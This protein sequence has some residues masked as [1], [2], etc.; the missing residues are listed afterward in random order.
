MSRSGYKTERSL[1]SSPQKKAE[2]I[3]ILDKKFN[4]RRAVHNKSGRK[5][6]ELRG[7]KEEWI[8]NFSERLDI[9]YATP[10]RRDTG[11]VGTDGGKGE[12]KQKRYLFWK[13]LD[14]LEIITNKNFPSEALEHDLSF[15]QMCNFLKKHKEVA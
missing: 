2:M 1:P 6:N 12:Y 7:E 11:Y 10:G 13:L 5:N 9:T 4:L 8:E 15:C 3:G 14:L